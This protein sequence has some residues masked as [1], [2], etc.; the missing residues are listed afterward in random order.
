MYLQQVQLQTFA[1]HANVAGLTTTTRLYSGKASIGS[2]LTATH[3][4]INTEPAYPLDVNG[5][6][7]F[8]NLIYVSNGTGITGEVL[9]SQGGSN[10]PVWVLQQTLRLVLP[11]L[12]TS[13]M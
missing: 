8:G 9:L 6:A 11:S 4:G 3:I 7:R 13:I 12:F 10:S 1:T 5:E 2:T